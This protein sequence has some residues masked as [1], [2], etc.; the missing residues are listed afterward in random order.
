MV[1]RLPAFASIGAN[2]NA[3]VTDACKPGFTT[4]FENQR[5]DMFTLEGLVCNTPTSATALDHCHAIEGAYQDLVA[6]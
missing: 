3:T 2:H 5:V 6:V 4:F 1:A